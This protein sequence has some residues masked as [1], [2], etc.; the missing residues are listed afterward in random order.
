VASKAHTPNTLLSQKTNNFNNCQIHLGLLRSHTSQPLHL[1][2]PS[3]YMLL[4]SLTTLLPYP[5]LKPDNPTRAQKRLTSLHTLTPLQDPL[6]HAILLPI[7][8]NKKP[9]ILSFQA[10]HGLLFP[11]SLCCLFSPTLATLLLTPTPTLSHLSLPPITC[12]Q[13]QAKITNQIIALTTHI[14]TSTTYMT[15]RT[16][17][18]T[19]RT[20][21]TMKK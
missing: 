21:Y 13:D 5:L 3:N 1:P 11:Q 20:T 19:T 6:L 10:I 14:T 17:Y 8:L 9:Q 4:I 7:P 12:D 15:T 18:M 16:T 2:L